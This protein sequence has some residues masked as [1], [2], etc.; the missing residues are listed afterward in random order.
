MA[1]QHGLHC[2]KC[3][4]DDAVH[5]TVTMRVEGLLIEDGVDYDAGGDFEWEATDPAR[6]QKCGW[7]GKVNNLLYVEGTESDGQDDDEDEDEGGN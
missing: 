7:T 6:C 1:N 5:I 4:S 3:K 2:P